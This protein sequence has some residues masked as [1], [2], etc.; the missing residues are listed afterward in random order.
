MFGWGEAALPA[1][2]N[3]WWVPIAGPLVGGVIGGGAYCLLIR[4]YLPRGG[5][6]AATDP[7]VLP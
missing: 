5:A 1:V 6:S 3:Y 7:Q 4:P 2:G